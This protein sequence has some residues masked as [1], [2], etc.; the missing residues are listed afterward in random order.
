MSVEHIVIST[1]TVSRRPRVVIVGAGFGGLS[2]A[3]ATGPNCQPL[4][5]IAPVAKQQG[6]YVANLLVARAEGRTLPAFRYRDLGSM[7]TIGRKRAVAQLGALK[8]PGFPAWLLWSLAHIYFLIGFRNR[9]TVAMNWGWNYL[10]FQRRTRLITG[11]SGSCIED[12][13]PAVMTAPLTAAEVSDPVGGRGASIRSG[14]K[15]HH[16]QSPQHVLHNKISNKFDPGK[17]VLDGPSAAARV[18]G[19][20]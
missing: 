2:A 10:T 15:L 16:Q 19:A 9:L 11:I 7:A 12:V 3:A 5:G 14:T 18:L 20:A 8:I 13:L 6:R 1:H 4:P 17:A